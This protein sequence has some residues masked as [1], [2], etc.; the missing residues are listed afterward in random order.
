MMRGDYNPNA[1][2][3]ASLTAVEYILD[4][5]IPASQ[6]KYFERFYVLFTNIMAL[7][8]IQRREIFAII[9]AFDEITLLMEMGLYEEARQ[10][11]G[12]ELM[13]MQ[14]S[15]SVDGFQTLFGQHGIQRTEHIE[16]VLARTK[17]RKGIINRIA[18]GFG[19]KKKQEYIEEEVY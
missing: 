8:N 14:V 10:L 9:L 4:P 18:G 3:D 13:K 5:S 7:G 1:I 19:G 15:R 2:Q 16:K 17:K 6:R 12:R 11:M